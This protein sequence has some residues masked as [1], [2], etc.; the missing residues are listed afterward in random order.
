MSWI[1]AAVY[2]GVIWLVF[3]KLRLL[4]LTLPLTIVLASVGPMLIVVLCPVFSSLHAACRGG[5]TD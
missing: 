3:A 5:R 1:L 2:C 4:R